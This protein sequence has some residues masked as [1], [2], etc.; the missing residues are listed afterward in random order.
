MVAFFR[1]LAYLLF[2]VFVVA[3][4]ILYA[5]GYRW[6]RVNH[7]IVKTSLIAFVSHASEIALFFDDAYVANA[8]P[9]QI[10][11]VLPGVHYVRIT[12]DGFTTW[13][14]TVV[15]DENTVTRLDHVLLVPKDLAWQTILED[16]PF[17]VLNSTGDHMAVFGAD[18]GIV[19]FV[20]VGDQTE[21]FLRS[22]NLYKGTV[23][24]AAW[25]QDGFFMVLFDD[26]T[27]QYFDL[28]NH[29]VTV[30]TV[31]PDFADLLA[32]NAYFDNGIFVRTA[33]G[34]LQSLAYQDGAWVQ[35]PLDVLSWA[36][37]ADGFVATAGFWYAQKGSA[38]WQIARS[39]GTV[40]LLPIVV[41][42]PGSWTNVWDAP[43]AKASVVFNETTH[44][45]IW[46]D[47]KGTLGEIVSPDLESVTDVV[48]TPES[49]RFL[50]S[51]AGDVYAV[52]PSVS[53]E[54]VFVTRF[55]HVIDGLAW[56]D[57]PFHFLVF[58][59]HSLVLC[60]QD[61]DNCTTLASDIDSFVVAPDYYTI[62]VHTKTFMIQALTLGFEKG[63]LSF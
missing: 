35:Q 27:F 29:K 33:D 6:D 54:P 8:L 51:V 46:I 4:V 30:A 11:S 63:F 23:R 47:S 28:E 21:T 52:D 37:T 49:Q 12:K 50:F 53:F 42:G 7:K 61:G 22:Y 36:H 17:T 9:F 31:A 18:S 39:D 56:Y 57:D 32:D 16:S 5:A 59:D 10:T 19:S 40:H 48:F 41:D 58:Q 3:A 15:V 45:L 60:E 14:K 43:D 2:F 55:S 25:V 62:F 20:Q 44:T 13:E 38:L 34:V 26:D 24:L 1:R